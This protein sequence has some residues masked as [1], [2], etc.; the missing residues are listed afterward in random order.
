MLSGAIQTLSKQLRLGD[1]SEQQKSTL[2]RA[3]AMYEFEAAN[4][5]RRTGNRAATVKHLAACVRA[6]RWRSP[7]RVIDWAS[8]LGY[9][10]L[11]I[12]RFRWW[13]H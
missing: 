11:G 2:A 3:L 6:G 12:K 13:R 4:F 9:G 7:G 1:L 5:E 10:I 8:L